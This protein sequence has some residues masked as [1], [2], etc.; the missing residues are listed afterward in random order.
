MPRQR[1]PEV[2]ERLFNRVFICMNCGSKNKADLQKV[3]QKK[4]RCRNCKSKDLRPIHKEH[5]V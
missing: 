4:I 5:K 1:I 2:D 3:K